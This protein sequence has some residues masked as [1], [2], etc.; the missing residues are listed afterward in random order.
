[1]KAPSVPNTG[2]M[3]D[4]WLGGSHYFPI[5]VEAAKLFEDAYPNCQAFFKKL[6]DFN[7][8]A[9][10]YIESQGIN[11]F[12]VFAAG[13]PTCGNVHEAV[14]RAKVLYTDID[15][16]NIQL[17][18]EI[19]ASNLNADYTF[20]DATNLDTLEQLVVDQVLEPIYCLGIIFLGISAF[21]NDETLANTLDKLYDWVPV[22][23]FMALDFD[24][25][26]ALEYPKLLKLLEDMDAP[27]VMRNP[28]RI[29]PLLGRWQLTEHGILPVEAWQAEAGAN[30][31]ET[32]EPVFSYGCVVYK[33][34]EEQITSRD[35]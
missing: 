5:D 25:E 34:Q 23:S 3:V 19:L 2:R 17:G 29:R 1:M 13:V 14:P 30:L 10:R 7:G 27:L 22:G 32:K 28:T 9:S 31:I 24:G 15:S 35:A 6:R 12:I 11:R 33:P 4:Y 26:A 20:C 8:R 18:R 16:V 21:I